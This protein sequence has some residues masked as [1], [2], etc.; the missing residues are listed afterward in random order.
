M[1]VQF[2]LVPKY[3]FFNACVSKKQLN[4]CIEV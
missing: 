2:E 4:A 1:S 3:M